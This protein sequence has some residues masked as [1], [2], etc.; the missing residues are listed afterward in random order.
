MARKQGIDAAGPVGALA[1]TLPPT[2]R[3]GWLNTGPK[4]LAYYGV[5]DAAGWRL[6]YISS[7]NAGMVS[8][9][10]PMVWLSGIQQ[11]VERGQTGTAL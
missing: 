7:G 4:S 3:A 11:V 9:L 6:T 1:R 8:F 10:A 2:K 5:A